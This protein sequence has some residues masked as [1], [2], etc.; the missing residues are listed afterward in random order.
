MSDRHM[1]VRGRH[2][3]LAFAFRRSA[4]YLLHALRDRLA[5]GFGHRPH[6]LAGLLKSLPN[7]RRFLGRANSGNVRSMA[8]ISARS[9]FN[10]ASAP[11]AS[12]FAKPFRTQSTDPLATVFSLCDIAR[13]CFQMM[14][15]VS[16][17]LRHDPAD[18]EVAVL[19]V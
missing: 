19:G 17:H 16:G 18:C 7:G 15:V 14:D 2:F 12:Q 10:T 9:C 11:T 13:S 1:L 6:A 3:T 5:L 8:M 4:Q